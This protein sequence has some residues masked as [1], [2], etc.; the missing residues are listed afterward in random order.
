MKSMIGI[1]LDNLIHIWNL[2]YLIYTYWFITEA[3]KERDPYN[4]KRATFTLD[5]WIDKTL[6]C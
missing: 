4:T 2:P 3:F 5:E 1:L 6:Y